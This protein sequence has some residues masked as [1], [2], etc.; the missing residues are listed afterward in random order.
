MSGKLHKLTSTS[1]L[2]WSEIQCSWFC[3]SLQALGS[4]DFSKWLA[5]MAATGVWTNQQCLG[6]LYC[7]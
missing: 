7:L 3:Y 6:I 5:F 2:L 4:V 1:G